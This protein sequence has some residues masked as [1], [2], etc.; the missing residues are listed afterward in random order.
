MAEPTV[1][2]KKVPKQAR[3]K[4]RVEKILSCTETLLRES[5]V[6]AVSTTSIAQAA[7]IPVG[8]I[9][10]YFDGKEDIL[11][12]LYDAAYNDIEAVMSNELSGARSASF[13]QLIHSMLHAFWTAAKA[14]PTFRPLTRWANSSRSLWETTPTAD[15]SLGELIKNTLLLAGIRI[16]PE[17]E[18]VVLTTTVTLVSIL[19]DLA[20]EE[21][22]EE[23][24]AA[25]MDELVIL[26][27][28]YLA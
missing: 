10:Q 21:Q 7:N 12:Q 14:H 15:S 6:A 22:S 16:P 1:K 20:I 3:A 5:G 26:L 24:A 4:A 13:D 8:S 23:K 25:I 17:R 9:Y 11:M 19:V 2:T 18:D 28:K 27:V